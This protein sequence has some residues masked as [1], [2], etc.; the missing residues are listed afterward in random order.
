LGYFHNN[1]GIRSSIIL[2]AKSH[3]LIVFIYGPLNF[4]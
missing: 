4:S 2:R 3:L 1:P